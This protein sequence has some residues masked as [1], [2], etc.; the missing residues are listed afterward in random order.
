VPH[1]RVCYHPPI[2]YGERDRTI[3]I[4]FL[5]WGIASRP[6]I[7]LDT[8][9][10]RT[11]GYAYDVGVWDLYHARAIFCRAVPNLRVAIRNFCIA[12]PHGLAITTTDQA[13]FGVL[14]EQ[15][16]LAKLDCFASQ[17]AVSSSLA[18]WDAPTDA[19]PR[20]Q[21]TSK[22]TRLPKPGLPFCQPNESLGA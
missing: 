19:A 21:H 22:E 8:M 3:G 18:N 9:V 7:S 15:Y 12:A 20:G 16:A 10:P 11:G 1:D 14:L 13:A 17:D 5:G 6:P 2:Y 4:V